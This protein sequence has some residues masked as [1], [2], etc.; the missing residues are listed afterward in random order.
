MTMFR[1][2]CLR[3]QA[4]RV[5]CFLWTPPQMTEAVIVWSFFTAASDWILLPQVMVDPCGARPSM[6]WGLNCNLVELLV[7]W[8]HFRHGWDWGGACSDD[9]SPSSSGLGKFGGD[10]SMIQGSPGHIL[11][12]WHPAK[13]GLRCCSNECRAAPGNAV[14]HLTWV[15]PNLFSPAPMR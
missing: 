14:S 11:L 8:G 3:W 7:T 2:Q 10:S 12:L 4:I 13:R 6:H 9:V 15:H 5:Q 1:V